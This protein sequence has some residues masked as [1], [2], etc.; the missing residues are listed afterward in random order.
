VHRAVVIPGVVLLSTLGPLAL[1]LSAPILGFLTDFVRY[2]Y[3]RLSDP[4]RPA[5]VLPDEPATVQPPASAVYVPTVY[6]NA[7]KVPATTSVPASR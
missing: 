3:G 4:P 7:G 2:T 1:I 6:R 5:G